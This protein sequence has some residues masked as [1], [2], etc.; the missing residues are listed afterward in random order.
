MLDSLG[1]GIYA[2]ELE[3]S[4]I[5]IDTLSAVDTSS[6]CGVW[7]TSQ[8]LSAPHAALVNGT[9]IQGFEIDDVFHR[10]PIHVGAVTLPALIAVAERRPK[11]TGANF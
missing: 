8:R 1:C 9:L 2:A 4:R 7:G 5:L 11:M 6:G 3:W 10:G